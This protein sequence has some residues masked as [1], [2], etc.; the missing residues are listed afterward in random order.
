MIKMNND[1]YSDIYF[2]MLRET[3]DGSKKI[4]SI[5]IN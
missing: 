1:F 2:M 4:N 3:V 5:I